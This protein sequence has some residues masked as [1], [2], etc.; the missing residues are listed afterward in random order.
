LATFVPAVAAAVLLVAGAQ[1]TGA[2][3]QATTTLKM[4]ASWPAALTLYDN[5]KM[6]AERVDKLSGGRLKIETMPAGTVVP[7]FEVL[8]ASSKRV[9]DGAHTW[10]AYWTGKHKAAVLFTGGPGGTFGM[11]FIDVIGWMYE[12]GGW[13][14]YQEFYRDVLK[15]N[16]IPIPILPA[17]PQAFGW[18]KKPIKNLADFK[19]MKCRQTG[20]AAE[21]FTEMGMRVVNMP[22]GEII[23]AAERGVIDCAEWVGGV[24]D[25]K[26]GFH[27]IWKYHYTPGMHENVTVGELII[28]REVWSKL[29]ADQQEIIKSAAMETFVRWWARWQKQ[30]ADALAELQE[31]HK[32][33]VLK[34]P[35]DILVEFL[36]AWDRIATR[37]S[38]KDPFFKKVL[39]SQRQYAAKVVP[40]KRF[41]FPP[42]NFAADYYWPE[43]K[44]T[45][46]STSAPASAPAAKPAPAVKPGDKKQ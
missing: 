34:T 23:P 5:F 9:I 2:Q 14:L 41:M 15:L 35:D 13:E 7:A 1:E 40:A 29:P 20:I 6:F 25:L 21:V 3:G 12:G 4:Q 28:N 19:G 43:K 44:G 24:E 39:D 10:A 36:K 18:F 42:Y 11:D 37:E 45:A 31:K 27:N 17:G 26:L 22:G 8:D 32:V 38:E 46:G 16:V 33:Q 30:N